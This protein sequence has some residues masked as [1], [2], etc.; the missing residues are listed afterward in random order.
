MIT[1]IKKPEMSGRIMVYIT[2]T[3]EIAA[4]LLHN[5]DPR[6][7]KVDA[8]TVR[9]Y[10]QVLKQWMWKDYLGD[11]MMVNES[12]FFMQGQ[13]RCHAVI[14]TGIP[15]N[16]KLEWNV[17]DAEF[18]YL[19]QPKRR[20]TKDFLHCDNAQD[21]S[22]VGNLMCALEMGYAPLLS[23]IQAKITPTESVPT[24]MNTQFCKANL[25]RIQKAYSLGR[26][27]YDAVGSKGGRA[28]FAFIVAFMEW[29]GKDFTH[30]AED[31]CEDIP[32]IKAAA[33]CKA[34]IVKKTRPTKKDILGYF[35][36]A[37]EYYQKGMMPGSLNKGPDYIDSYDKQ[38]QEMRLKK[39]AHTA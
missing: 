24:T 6:Q 5:L 33:K 18:D 4:D 22:S 9:K 37:F 3:T 16:V 26:R 27:M 12:G 38:M 1:S 39:A 17:P 11:P 13:H 20:M 19:D 36:M 30:F 14:N 31:F 29:M 34:A 2:I 7:R 21:I 8:H 35:L 25:Q 15:M 32:E 10:E 28:I 23:V